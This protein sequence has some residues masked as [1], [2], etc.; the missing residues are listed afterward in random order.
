MNDI[1][2]TVKIVKH[3]NQAELILDGRLDS[4]TTADAEPIIMDFAE[5]Y[6]SIVLN[7]AS[8]DYISSAGLRLIKKLHIAMK[9]KNGE[10]IIR[11]V[12]RLVMEV[13]E[14]TGFVAL[15]KFE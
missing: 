4:L 11:N 8:M 10:L 12:N 2:L 13:F 14:M 6:P 3:E 7:L 1:K 9:K 5:K 15:F